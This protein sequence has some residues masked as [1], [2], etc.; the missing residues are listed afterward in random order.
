[1]VRKDHIHVN[2][3][4]SYN[5]LHLIVSPQNLEHSQELSCFKTETRLNVNIQTIIL[6]SKQ[7]SILTSLYWKSG[8]I[9]CT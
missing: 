6:R 4:V 5:A 7:D 1:M 2:C 8:K 9:K 3:Y